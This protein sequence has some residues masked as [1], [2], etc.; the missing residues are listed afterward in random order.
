MDELGLAEMGA[1]EGGVE[2]DD[3]RALLLM[4]A[5]GKPGSRVE[6]EVQRGAETFETYATLIKQPP[7]R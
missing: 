3:A 1:L 7:L 2:V 6:F 4:I 5:Q